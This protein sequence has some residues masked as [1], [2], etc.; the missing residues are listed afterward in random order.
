[1]VDVSRIRNILSRI[2]RV[3]TGDIVMPDDHNLQTD[4]I[5]EL[6]NVVETLG[7]SPP[8]SVVSRRPLYLEA[9][10]A[11][12]SS[13][14][15]NAYTESYTLTGGEYFHPVAKKLIVQNSAAP[16][17]PPRYRFRCRTSPTTGYYI[18]CSVYGGVLYMRDG[19]PLP[20]KFDIFDNSPGVQHTYWAEAHAAATCPPCNPDECTYGC[21]DYGWESPWFLDSDFIVAA[22]TSIEGDVAIRDT[23]PGPCYGIVTDAD[24]RLY[25]FVI[26]GEVKEFYAWRDSYGDVVAYLPMGFK[27][28]GGETLEIRVKEGQGGPPGWEY[29]ITQLDY[30]I[31]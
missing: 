19:T 21:T 23:V 9:Y 30:L 31:T 25:E 15:E 29:M 7:P 13:D 17:N 16:L 20:S 28:Y 12:V 3:R 24:L 10:L 8:L 1:V 11:N 5:T 14:P 26:D 27:L 2:R 22:G 18:Y 6:T 4:A